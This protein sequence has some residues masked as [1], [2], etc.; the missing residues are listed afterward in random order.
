MKQYFM[1]NTNAELHFGDMI[2]LTLY[3]ELDNGNIKHKLECKFLPEI[4]PLLLENDII[5]E[6]EVPEPKK[7]ESSDDSLI[8]SMLKTSEDL[9]HRLESL[10]A[11]VVRLA[12][13]ILKKNCP[14]HC[15]NPCHGSKKT[16]RK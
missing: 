5:Y 2:E 15:S 11:V 12:D 14:K 8:Q 1:R 4:V 10:E 16:G 6:K 13:V 3:K 9:E 7:K